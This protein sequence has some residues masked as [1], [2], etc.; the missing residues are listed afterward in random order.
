MK[1]RHLI[2]I[3]ILLSVSVFAQRTEVNI[4]NPKE[5][6]SI[7]FCGDKYTLVSSKSSEYAR[8]WKWDSYEHDNPFGNNHQKGIRAIAYDKR[9]QKIA[10]VGLE[11]KIYTYDLTGNYDNVGKSDSD[12]NTMDFHPTKNLLFTGDELGRL[13]M[14]N[15]TGG[16]IHSLSHSD[17]IR[18]IDISNDGKYLAVATSKGMMYLWNLDTNEKIFSKTGHG[19]SINSVQISPNNNYILT[20]GE[21]K[22]VIL[23][24]M[25]GT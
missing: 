21:D 8:L 2:F 19:K 14:W 3:F 24:T 25:K 1:K 15:T 4:K 17:A 23:W 16:K 18:A 7:I 10:T 9:T 13:M 11:R 22:K 6:N 5:A 20:G 12:I